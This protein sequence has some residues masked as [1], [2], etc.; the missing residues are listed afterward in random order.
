[1]KFLALDS[2][3]DGKGN[4]YL[5]NYFDGERHYTFTDKRKAW[6]FLLS[7]S[8]NKIFAHNLEYDL[9]NIAFPFFMEQLEFYYMSGRLLYA[10]I[11]NTRKKFFDSF[12]FSFSSLKNIGKSIRLEKIEGEDYNNIEYCRRDTEIVYKY[13]LD[14]NFQLK[15]EFKL[16]PKTTLAGTAQKIF[17]ERFEGKELGGK[18][19]NKE[20]LHAY[21]GGRCEAYKIGEVNNYIFELDINS[22]YPYV[23]SKYSYPTGENYETKNPDTE[24]YISQVD[25]EIDEKVDIPVLPYR[26]D[27]LYFPVGRFTTWATHSEIEKAR[28]EQQIKKI[29]YLRSFNFI[30]RG[31]VFADYI[32]FFYEK[33]KKA[34]ME[35]NTFQDLFY[36]LI[37]NSTYGRFALSGNLQKYEFDKN[38]KSIVKDILIKNTKAINYALALYV[39][40]YGRLEL[41]NLIKRV[42]C[43]G[44]IILYTDTDSCYFTF[45]GKIDLQ[46]T[47]E[48]IYNEIPITPNLGDNSLAVYA[49][50]YFHNAKQYFLKTIYDFEKI[51]CKGVPE[52][53]RKEFLKSG[54]TEYS[55]P[56]KLRSFTHNVDKSFVPNYW[57][58]FIV[59]KR[60]EYKKRVVH[61][62]GPLYDTSPIFIKE[63]PAGRPGVE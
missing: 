5:I 49:S 34:K 4:I 27:R 45:P 8:I 40:S 58:P 41:F 48:K 31:Y 37:L 10:K 50:G 59:E 16:S 6:D 33:R 60:N 7:Y 9:I 22:C 11:K 53:N 19:T 35:K 3:D 47:I 25:V 23:M 51:R 29:K 36:K 13:I 1:M 18:N 32:N 17:L 38:M 42:Q 14:F 20:L 12:N 46:N 44:A 30:E 62:D 15:E 55:R 56:V 39:T 61:G 57:K 52:K 26:G 63:T 28:Q 21:Y 43:M 24:F 54:K 2:E